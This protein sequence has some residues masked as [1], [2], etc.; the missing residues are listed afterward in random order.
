MSH[1]ARAPIRTPNN[2]YTGWVLD[3]MGATIPLDRICVKSGILC[4]RCEARIESG[5]YEEW[6]VEV[7]RALLKL[8]P[9]LRS[10]VKYVKAHMVGGEVY[11][12]I[13]PGGPLPSWLGQEL[14]RILDRRVYLV[15]H[16]RDLRRL[17][18]SLL[19]PS[20]VLGLDYSYL[21]DGSTILQVKV[22]RMPKHGVEELARKVLGLVSG[23]EVAIQEE[24][25]QA[26]G[27]DI[28]PDK[29]DLRRALDKL[30]L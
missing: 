13:E 12:F 1:P 26:P 14:S 22:D 15:E 9:R 28:R 2:H 27:G 20:R 7:M 10:S 6:E 16:S 29:K 17:A 21:P 23:M 4:P 18:S 25:A 8:E 5:E 19:A 24:A 3:G 30:G 11:L